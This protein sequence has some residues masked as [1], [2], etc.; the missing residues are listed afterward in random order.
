MK[1]IILTLAVV[2]MTTF[3]ASAQASIGAGYLNS[4]SSYKV[5]N[6]RAR[7][8]AL[9]GF[10]AGVDYSIDLLNE[11][12]YVT[13]GIYFSYLTGRQLAGNSFYKLAGTQTDMYL[14]IPVNLS[15]GLDLGR[16]RGFIFLGPT[17]SVGCA[18]NMRLTGSSIIG[19][20][21]KTIDLY[22]ETQMGRFDVLLGGGI[23]FD[24]RE[25]ARISVGYHYGVINRAKDKSLAYHR[26][27]L[28]VGVAWI[29]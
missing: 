5:D 4:T 15:V 18:S 28:H 10:Y 8:D 29:F 17:F 14:N 20:G 19:N 25:A 24:I 12:F 9:N 16:S 1:K 27:E 2:A 7:G 11:F 13:P 6:M 26:G 21:S 3:T 23:G 22:K